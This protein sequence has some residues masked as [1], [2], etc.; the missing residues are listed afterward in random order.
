M[1]ERMKEEPHV[2]RDKLSACTPAFSLISTCICRPDGS[3]LIAKD[4]LD[5][6][7]LELG[8][9]VWLGM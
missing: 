5:G 9:F 3:V 6:L 4:R 1:L 8:I 7:L 2:A